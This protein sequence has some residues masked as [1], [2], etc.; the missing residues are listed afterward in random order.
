MGYGLIT[1]NYFDFKASREVLLAFF[2]GKKEGRSVIE[3]CDNRLDDGQFC[4]VAVTG[5]SKIV[6]IGITSKPSKRLFYSLVYF[7]LTSLSYSAIFP[8]SRDLEKALLS[9]FPDERLDFV[10]NKRSM[11][12]FANRG[13]MNEFLRTFKSFRSL[14]TSKEFYSM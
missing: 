3:A 8:G 14:S 4:Y 10:K 7:D 6:K 1:Q 9:S 2:W 11:E 12:W 13:R 5:N